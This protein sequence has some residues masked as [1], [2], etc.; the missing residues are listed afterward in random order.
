LHA[1][2]VVDP[3]LQLVDVSAAQ[4]LELGVVVAAVRVRGDDL[5]AAALKYT[6]E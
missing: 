4:A 6:K 5:E 2:V 3:E 1:A